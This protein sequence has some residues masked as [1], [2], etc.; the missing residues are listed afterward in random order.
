MKK[1]DWEKMKEE[2]GNLKKEV[3][4]VKDLEKEVQR[5]KE[6]AGEGRI[7]L[8]YLKRVWRL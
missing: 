5:L 2:L 1:E 3:E 6:L 7:K 8:W 4:K